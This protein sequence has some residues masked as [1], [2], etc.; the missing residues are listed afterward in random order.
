MNITSHIEWY[1]S[2]GVDIKVVV[3]ILDRS[4]SSRGKLKGHCHLSDVGWREDEV[5][6]SLMSEAMDKYGTNGRVI[7]ASYE[8]L[9]QMK[10]VYLCTIYHQL[11]IDLRYIPLF[12]DGNKKYL[13]TIDTES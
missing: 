6:L 12:S 9:M 3:S 8:G 2:R 1:L 5:A 10:E 11:G 13:T 7:A 4:A